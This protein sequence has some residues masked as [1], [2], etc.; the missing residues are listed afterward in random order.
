MVLGSEGGRGLRRVGARGVKGETDQKVSSLKGEG[1]GWA[2]DSMGSKT[3]P[4]NFYELF[5]ADF[6]PPSH[7]RRKNAYCVVFKKHV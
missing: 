4:N 5:D 3:P 7:N 2:G 1:R 6:D